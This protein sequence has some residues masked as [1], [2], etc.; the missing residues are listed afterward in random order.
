LS[1]PSKLNTKEAHRAISRN[2]KMQ[3]TKQILHNFAY[4]GADYDPSL[5]SNI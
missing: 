2:P 5:A 1:G 4:G 3:S